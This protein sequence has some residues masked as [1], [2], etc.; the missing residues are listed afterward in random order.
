MI[1][2]RRYHPGRFK[3]LD[4]DT[5][6]E[7]KAPGNET[8]YSAISAKNISEA[9]SLLIAWL[10]K[11]IAFKSI[12]GVGHRIVHGMNH[13]QPAIIDHKL[14]DELKTISRYDPDHLPGAIALI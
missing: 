9:A 6:F 13:V 4:A 12:S 8:I 1:T 11:N 5:S 7:Y 14:L 2:R 10:E 3:R